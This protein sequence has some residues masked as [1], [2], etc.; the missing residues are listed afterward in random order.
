ME[1]SSIFLHPEKETCSNVSEQS[2][3]IRKTDSF[4]IEHWERFSTFNFRGEFVPSDLSC[5]TF[6]DSLLFTLLA[7]FSEFLKLE[8]NAL[9]VLVFNKFTFTNKCSII[10]LEAIC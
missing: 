3:I 2:S 4:E 8:M 10:Y 6:E 9:K 5:S 1:E 7:S